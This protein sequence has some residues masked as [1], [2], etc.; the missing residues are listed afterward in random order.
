[1][2]WMTFVK[3]E[4]VRKAEE[5]LK[6]DFNLASKQAIGVRDARSLEIDKDG[7]FFIITG[8]DEGVKKC[9]ELIKDFVEKVDDS[10]LEKVKQKL[11]EEAD[12]AAEGFGGL[13]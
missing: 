5:I 3:K 9:Q 8:T 13:F 6:G 10:L 12:K 7:S 1:M 11:Q 4:N 2:E